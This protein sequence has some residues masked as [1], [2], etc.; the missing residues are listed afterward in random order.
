MNRVLLLLSLVLT[1][2][3]CQKKV[4]KSI[5]DYK[6]IWVD[7]IYSTMN[8]EE[9]VG[10]LFMVAAYSN[11]DSIHANSIKK[12]ILENHI[13]GLVFFQGGPIRQAKLTNQYQDR[14]KIPLMISIDAEWERV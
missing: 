4:E 3:S 7:S 5:V 12:M 14:S 8:L 6:V 11:R 13:G 9:K 2:G 1:L 10:Q